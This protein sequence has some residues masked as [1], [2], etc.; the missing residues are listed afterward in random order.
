MKNENK[1]KPYRCDMTYSV[2]LQQLERL[3]YL[4]PSFVKKLLVS[5]IGKATA[6]T[7]SDVV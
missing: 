3:L 2:H 7:Q 4:I 6:A 1:S 5:H